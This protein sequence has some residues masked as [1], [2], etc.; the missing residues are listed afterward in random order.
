[1]VVWFIL[2]PQI[3]TVSKIFKELVR[4]ASAKISEVYRDF[5]FLDFSMLFTPR[6]SLQT[7]PGKLSEEKVD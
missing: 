6:I 7:L 5:L 4:A 3:A 1:M 2:E